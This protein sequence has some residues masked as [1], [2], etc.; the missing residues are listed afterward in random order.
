MKEGVVDG[1]ALAQ[2]LVAGGFRLKTLKE[3]E[4]DL[5]DVFMAITKG[6]VQ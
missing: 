5:E 1:S 2:H 4:I 6:I 3:E